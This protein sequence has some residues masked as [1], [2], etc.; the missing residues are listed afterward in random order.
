MDVK[1]RGPLLS[2]S[3][4]RD[5]CN[6]SEV[7]TAPCRTPNQSQAFKASQPDCDV[8]VIDTGFG[9]NYLDLLRQGQL[10]MLAA[11]LPLSDPDVTVG[12]VLSHEQLVLLVARDDPFARRGSVGLQDFAG[13]ALAD[14]PVLPHEM[15][16]TF[17]WDYDAPRSC[18]APG[19]GVRLRRNIDARRC[20]RPRPSHS[21]ELSQLLPARRCGCSADQGRTSVSNRPGV[22]EREPVSQ[23]P[24]LRQRCGR[25]ALP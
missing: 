7:F 1:R 22:A 10:D 19:P 16:D 21:C 6:K 24:S 13:R 23:S 2:P 5:S 3:L 9:R 11:R 17:F 25:C 12:P 20:W 18:W 14:A 15:M 8:Q 4:G